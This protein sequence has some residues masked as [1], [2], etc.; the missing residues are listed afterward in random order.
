[1]YAG[2]L[3]GITKANPED[4][5][6]TYP[7]IV[8]TGVVPG[9]DGA[10]T[11]VASGKNVTRF[12][13][14]DR[15]YTISHSGYQSGY[16]DDAAAQTSLGGSLDGTFRQYGVFSEW[17]LVAIP[18][19][20]DFKDA[21]SLPTA[22]ITAWNALY[23][24]PGLG[25]KAGDVVL[26]QGTGGVSMFAAQF[27]LAAGATVIATTS[28]AEKKASLKH[29]GV[30]HVIN[31]REVQ[32]WGQRAKSLTRKG[33]G[34]DFIIEV[35]GGTMLE[36]SL[37]AIRRA[38]VIA[39]CGAVGGL[40][41]ADPGPALIR[42]WTSS[43]VVRGVAVGSR[44]HAEEMNK[45]IEAT[46]LRPVLDEK[47]FKLEDLKDGYEYLGEQKHVGKVIIDCSR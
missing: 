6:G 20:L 39:V 13:A 30:Q 44:A 10:G 40:G 25:L 36:Q 34:V 8:E 18:D 7:F 41:G 28:N 33:Q 45:A 12:K 9:S 14:G 29:L 24:I 32:D 21:A 31:Y 38:G 47:V 23:G 19:G 26:T 4:I 1:M 37:A 42:A 22:G 5:Q 17:G 46:S 11:V 35:G 16:L 3:T 43:C 27:A 2:H 15:I